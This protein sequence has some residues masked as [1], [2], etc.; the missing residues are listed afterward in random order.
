MALCFL[1]NQEAFILEENCV[2]I[3]S[4]GILG[5]LDDLISNSP[6]TQQLGI[7]WI[8]FTFCSIFHN[9][10]H[11]FLIFKAKVKKL[12]KNDKKRSNGHKHI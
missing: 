5:N 11:K 6:F 9:L 3:L 7:S 1:S 4:V 8:K 12:G 2:N 10:C